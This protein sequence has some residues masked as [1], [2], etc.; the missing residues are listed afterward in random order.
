MKVQKNKGGGGGGGGA[1]KGSENSV[2]NILSICTFCSRLKILYWFHYTPGSDAILFRTHSQSNIDCMLVN[3][4]SL[5]RP[6][7]QDDHDGGDGKRVNFVQMM[8]EAEEQREDVSFSPV[9]IWKP[10]HIH[11]RRVFLKPP[12]SP[13]EES[14]GRITPR[15]GKGTRSFV[16]M[17]TTDLT[18][19]LPPER[20]ESALERK[21]HGSSLLVSVEENSHL[22]L[23]RNVCWCM[24]GVGG[25]SYSPYVEIGKE[26]LLVHVCGGGQ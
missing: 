14:R 9:L 6:H 22:R 16:A 24:C 1:T 5:C 17:K 18:E 23:G 2:W 25:N 11:R 21:V 20:T 12:T 8:L 19:T 7:S 15:G 10:G 4:L 3:R 13:S 26:C